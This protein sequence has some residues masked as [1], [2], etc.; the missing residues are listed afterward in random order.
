LWNGGMSFHGGFV[1]LALSLWIVSVV[2]RMDLLTFTDMVAAVIAWPI[3]LGRVCN[4]VN[5]ELPGRPTD[6]AWAVMFPEPWNDFPRHPSQLYEALTEG[7]ILGVLMFFAWRH[8]SMRR[9]LVSAYFIVG[10]GSLRF[11]TEYSREPDPQLGLL[12]L[13]LSLGQWLCLGMVCFGAGLMA[14]VVTVD[15]GRR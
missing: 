10:Y 5:G 1:G 12:W 2:R 14:K 8:L 15:G 4:F 13:G 6:I 3:G 7:L 9:G 11:F